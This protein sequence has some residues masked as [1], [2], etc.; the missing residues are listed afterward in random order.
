[1]Q[2]ALLLVLTA[3]ADLIKPDKVLI[4]RPAPSITQKCADPVRL[5][6]RA[7]TQQEVEAYW[8]LDRVNLGRCGRKHGVLVQWGDGIVDALSGVAE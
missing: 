4:D 8:G 3:C 5:P 2:I 6:D 1:M 7:M